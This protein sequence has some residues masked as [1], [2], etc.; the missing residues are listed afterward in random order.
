MAFKRPEHNIIAEL[1]ASMKQDVLIDSKC[2]FGGG[3]AIVLSLDE[4]RQ[5]LDVDFLCADFAD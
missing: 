3:T 2:Y 5:S 4:Y 1:L